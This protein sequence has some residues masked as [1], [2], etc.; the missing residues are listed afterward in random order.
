M[1]HL[2]LA[3]ELL[4][5]IPNL[6]A[7][8]FGI[9]NIAPDAGIPD[10]NWERFDPPP[11]VTH[12]SQGKGRRGRFIR[13][14]DFYRQFEAALAPGTP[15]SRER[16][17]L[18]G[19]FFHLLSDRLFDAYIWSLPE[20]DIPSLSDSARKELIQIVREE[21][22]AIDQVY[23]RDHPRAFFWTV[24][25]GAT[26]DGDHLPFLPAA[27]IQSRVEMLQD[28]YQRKDERTAE[29]YALELEYFSSEM[30]IDFVAQTADQLHAIYR[31]IWEESANL[32]G[33]DSALTLLEA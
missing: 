2:R 18:L 32:D 22:R 11:N 31:A 7:A 30:I 8:Q 29:L 23:V 19:Y 4:E 33:L 12:Y 17:F 9:G 10:E 16:S 28:I 25:V 3:G 14:L 21:W 27:A 20:P 5:R 26:Y 13:D 24:F 1:T 6:D 15:D